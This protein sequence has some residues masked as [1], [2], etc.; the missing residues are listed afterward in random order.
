M[1]NMTTG[2]AAVTLSCTLLLPG[3]GF[4]AGT[5]VG[6]TAGYM[7]KDRGYEVRSPITDDRE[8]GVRLRSPVTKEPTASS[9]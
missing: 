7:M 3:C 2:M 4:I 5:A 6:G 8:E 9:R 1:N